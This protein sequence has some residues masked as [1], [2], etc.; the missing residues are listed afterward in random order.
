MH[1]ELYKNDMRI[2]VSIVLDTIIELTPYQN[3]H[4]LCEGSIQKCDS[5]QLKI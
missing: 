2:C 1:Y 5:M 3:Q 4:F